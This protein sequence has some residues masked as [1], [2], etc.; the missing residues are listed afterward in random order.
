MHQVPEQPRILIGG[1]GRSGTSI[2]AS[3]F[4]LHPDT[5]YFSEPGI[6]MWGYGVFRVARGEVAPEVY[7]QELIERHRHKLILWLTRHGH[8]EADEVYSP[9]YISAVLQW[10][11]SSPG[12][13]LEQAARF[14]DGLFSLG[15]Q[16]WGGRTWA[17]KTP[18]TILHADLLGH[19][20]PQMRYLHI[21]REPKDIY[22]S[23]RG[24]RWGPKT[25][26]EFVHWYNDVLRQAW[27]A[28]RGLDESR[29]MT[30]SMEHL[31]R[32]PCHVAWMALA[33]T[34]LDERSDVIQRF[35]AKVDARQSHTGRWREELGADDVHVI[36]RQCS[37]MYRRWLL[38]AE[39]DAQLRTVLPS[40]IATPR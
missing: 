9:R 14:V 17:E 30:L 16:R 28:Q 25:V 5:F 35:A 3:L 8:E 19:M 23:V 6:W 38:K 2:L 34:G 32:D 40:A 13:R 27:E 24:V 18:H 33:F 15:L 22:A 20:F 7:G 31:V 29:Y 39:K 1:T 10:A 26:A 11:F 37:E 12:S 21:I 4:G 36:D